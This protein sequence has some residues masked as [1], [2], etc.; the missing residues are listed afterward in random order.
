MII[1]EI[2]LKDYDVFDEKNHFNSLKYQGMKADEGLSDEFCLA[3]IERFGEDGKEE[4]IRF[5]DRGQIF[6]N[7]AKRILGD[8][9]LKFSNRIPVEWSD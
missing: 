1:K 3:V 7:Q 8:E 4:I 5:E 2:T 6:G 9:Y